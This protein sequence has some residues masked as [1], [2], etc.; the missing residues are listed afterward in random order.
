MKI[1][2]TVTD[3]NPVIHAGG[4]PDISSGIIE[5]PDDKIPRI[6]NG[7]FESKAWAKEHNKPF[8]IQITFSLLEEQQ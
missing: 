1:V 7:Y 5:I 3:V 6:V 2:A 4:S 8:L